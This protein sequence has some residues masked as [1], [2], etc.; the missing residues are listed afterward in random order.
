MWMQGVARDSISI[1]SS[2]FIGFLQMHVF[3]IETDNVLLFLFFNAIKNENK[4]IIWTTK[5]A[6]SF[7]FSPPGLFLR[8]IFATQ[9]TTV[10]I[11]PW[12]RQLRS[13]LLA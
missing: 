7:P 6:L 9:L 2:L 8:C 13:Y 4:N 5:P 3:I 12:H 10:Q 11:L 1:I